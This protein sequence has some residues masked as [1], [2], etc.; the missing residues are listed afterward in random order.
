MIFQPS[1]TLQFLIGL[2]FS[3]LSFGGMWSMIRGSNFKVQVAGA[4]LSVNQ[5]LEDVEKIKES[6]DD[7]V[8]QLKAEPTV[9]SI[10]IEAYEKELEK[11]ETEILDTE[12]RI[13]EDLKDLIDDDAS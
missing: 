4:N 9:S 3:L 7:T 5:R 8:T 2:S 6:L 12:A 13:E 1:Q 11:A 10:K